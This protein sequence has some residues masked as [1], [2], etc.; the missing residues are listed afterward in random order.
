MLEGLRPYESLYIDDI[1]TLEFMERLVPVFD[2]WRKGGTWGHVHPW[3]ETTI[4]VLDHPFFAVT[5]P[6]GTFTIEGLP[7]GSYTLGAWHSRLGSQEIEIAVA[8]D[9]KG[10]AD[11]SFSQP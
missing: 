2:L 11:F 5:G 10:S 7:S 8:A 3:M 1:P 6:D 9:G 4:F